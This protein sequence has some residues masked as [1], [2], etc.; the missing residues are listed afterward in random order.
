MSGNSRTMMIV[1]VCPTDLTFDETLFT[2]QFATRV[3]NITLGPAQKQ[4]HTKNLEVTIKS[5]RVE[6]KE[7]KRGKTTADEALHELR[8]EIKKMSALGMEDLCHL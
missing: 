7:A 8:K 6:L 1:T 4:S 5:L 2:L 3:R